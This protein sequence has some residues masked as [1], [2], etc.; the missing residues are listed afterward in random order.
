MRAVLLT[1]LLAATPVQA[2][3]WLTGQNSPVPMAGGKNRGCCN[4]SDCHPREVRVAADGQIEIL[5]R[6]QWWP[7]T[8][9]RWYL[10][11]SPDG[12][13]WGCM[14]PSDPFPRCVFLGFGA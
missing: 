9:P 6:E 3:D 14:L 8:D 4:E 2:H 5:I 11:D 13:A 7:A 12:A 10:G 1:I